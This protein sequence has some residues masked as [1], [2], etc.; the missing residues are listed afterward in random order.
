[1]LKITEVIKKESRSLGSEVSERLFSYITAGLGLV[2]GLAWNE[3]IK[4]A[5]EYFFPLD[6]NTLL[7][8]F[9]YA[10]AISVIV[11]VISIYLARILGQEDKKKEKKE[12]E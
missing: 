11:V 6:G 10:T 1:M 12:K 7:A 3:A 9:F 8:K 2:A 5:I 4:S